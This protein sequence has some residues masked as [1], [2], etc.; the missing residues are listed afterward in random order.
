MGWYDMKLI[1][2]VNASDA[3]KK[4]IVQ[5]LPLMQAHQ[6]MCLV[7][8]C[9]PH[10]RFYGDIEKQCT[11]QDQFEQLHKMTVDEEFEKIRIPLS[12]NVVLSAADVKNLEPFIDWGG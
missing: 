4:L 7:D 3:F 9:N 8:R 11:S 6:L 1:D 10:L 2:I 5:D 12:A